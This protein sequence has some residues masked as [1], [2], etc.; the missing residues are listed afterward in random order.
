MRK[1]EN[2]HCA[3]S[4]LSMGEESLGLKPGLAA[5]PAQESGQEGLAQLTRRQEPG[6]GGQRRGE[7]LRAHAP[8]TQVRA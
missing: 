7:P 8:E 6:H 1:S 3:M 2:D 5:G 4:E